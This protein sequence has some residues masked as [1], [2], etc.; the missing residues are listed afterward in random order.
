[1]NLW[2]IAV[3]DLRLIG[4][5]R[6]AS[7]FLVLVPLLVVTIVAGALG[8]QGAGRGEARQSLATQH[9]LAGGHQSV[10]D[11]RLAQDNLLG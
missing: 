4:R 7:L 10:T 11:E 5:D 9:D 6:A 2:S 3:K 1:M 8:G